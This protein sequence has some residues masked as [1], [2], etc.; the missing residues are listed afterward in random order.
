MAKLLLFATGNRETDI[1]L[2][3][4]QKKLARHC[5]RTCKGI[6]RSGPQKV[7]KLIACSWV[8][9]MERDAVGLVASYSENT[10]FSKYSTEEHCTTFGLEDP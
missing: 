8:L 3:L 5:F 2:K 7:S 1:Y 10:G 4:C 6:V 9:S